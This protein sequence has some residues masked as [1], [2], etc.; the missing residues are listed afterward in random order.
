MADMMSAPYYKIH[1]VGSYRF[2]TSGLRPFHLQTTARWGWAAFPGEV[3][4]SSKILAANL[5]DRR[6]VKQ[7]VITGTVEFGGIRVPSNV[8]TE[9]SYLLQP[10]RRVD[11]TAGIA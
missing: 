1:A 6:N 4:E 10:F 8:F 5:W 11:R 3:V 7:G 2:P 9:V